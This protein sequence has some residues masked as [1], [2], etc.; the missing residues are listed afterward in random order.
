MYEI[1]IVTGKPSHNVPRATRYRRKGRNLYG[2]S[3][4]LGV[5]RIFI[6][7]AGLLLAVGN[8][9]ALPPCPSSGVFHNC[10]GAATFVS[11][12]EYVGEWKE[13]KGHGQGTMIETSGAKYVGEFKDGLKHGQG[14]YTY[15]DGDRYVGEWVGDNMHGQGTYTWADGAQYVGEYREDLRH[16]YG[17]FT[18]PDGETYEGEWREDRKHGEGIK[19]FSDGRQ[20]VG[21]FKFGKTWNAVGYKTDGTIT[22]VFKNGVPGQP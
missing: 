12:S 22:V 3:G 19:T 1:G 10:F 16:G 13:D 2:V 11:G 15:A 6:L 21:E 4:V 17:A 20:L 7:L 8:V 5:N 18:Y 9:Y 14:T